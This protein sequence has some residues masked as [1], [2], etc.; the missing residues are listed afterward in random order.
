MQVKMKILAIL[1]VFCDLV[2]AIPTSKDISRPQKNAGCDA[3]V[4]LDA[5]TNVFLNYTLHPHSTWRNMV[6]GAAVKIG[7]PDL[8]EQALRAA[9]QGTFAWMCV[10]TVQQLCYAKTISVRSRKTS[11]PSKAS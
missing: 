10:F 5:K 1:F 11:L 8:K 2:S 6:S 9:E 3:P 4:I 7:N